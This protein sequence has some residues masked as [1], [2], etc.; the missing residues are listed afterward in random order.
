[1][2]KLTGEWRGAGICAEVHANVRGGGPLAPGWPLLAPADLHACLR[3]CFVCLRI[4]RVFSASWPNRPVCFVCRKARRCVV[5][6]GDAFRSGCRRFARSRLP[7]ACRRQLSRVAR[8]ALATP[9][10]CCTPSKARLC[11][12][13][14][15]M[16]QRRP[17]RASRFVGPC[18]SAAA[19]RTCPFPDVPPLP[20]QPPP[21]AASLQI[22]RDVGRTAAAAVPCNVGDEAS[23]KAAFE[24]AI[25]AQGPVDILVNNAGIAA[26]GNVLKADDEEMERLFRVNVKGVFYCSKV[27]V[28]S[29][30]ESGEGGAIVNLGSIASLVR[31]RDAPPPPSL[32]RRLL[33]L[34]RHARSA[35]TTVSRT[36]CPR[37]RCWPCTR[38]CP[39]N[40]A[41]TRF[42]RG[43]SPFRN[44][45]PHS[46]RRTRS[47]ATDFVK[48]GIRC[49][50]RCAVVIELEGF[51][52]GSLCTGGLPLWG[53]G[54]WK[55]ALGALC[56]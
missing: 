19:Q 21:S 40:P 11:M 49:V 35:C 23:V 8:R 33:T 39:R 3:A 34:T 41:A 47:V 16:K 29:M 46:Q 10:R 13:W 9:F 56:R 5:V 12:C 52:G 4:P 2:F 20:L 42:V 18:G 50:G 24:A 44:G 32:P 22:N 1:M 45:G 7:V 53:L 30:L 27:G 25:A 14:T 55:L 54:G 43:V 51:C 17:R 26:I 6:R 48:Q 37:A 15:S 31:R 28:A 38:Y 36:A